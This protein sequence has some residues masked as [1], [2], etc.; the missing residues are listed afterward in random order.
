MCKNRLLNTETEDRCLLNC[1]SY[2]EN[3][4]NI[5]KVLMEAFPYQ[6]KDFNYL[7]VYSVE[8]LRIGEA[9]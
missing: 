5:H 3:S 8:E 6:P 4:V 9:T 2:V 7:H 1:Q